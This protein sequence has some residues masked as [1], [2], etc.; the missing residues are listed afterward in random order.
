MAKINWLKALSDYLA[1]ETYSYASIAQ[2]YGVSL[3]AVKKRASKK[4][5]AILR[6]ETILKVDQKLSEKIGNELVQVNLEHAKI[7]QQLQKQGMDFINS[8]KSKIKNGRQ[9]ISLVK[10]GVE[11]ERRALGADA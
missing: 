9:A 3:Q 11:I 8:N 2:K 1:D 6:R 4:R 10:A 5:W 7:G